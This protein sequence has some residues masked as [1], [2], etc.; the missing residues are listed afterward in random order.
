MS[1]LDAKARHGDDAATVVVA[2]PVAS[3]HVFCSVCVSLARVS[4][5]AASGG[6]TAARFPGGLQ[7]LQYVMSCQTGTK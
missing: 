6:W 4:V 1:F 3:K 7:R 5:P 2:L